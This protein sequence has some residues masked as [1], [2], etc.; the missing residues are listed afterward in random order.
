ML[1]VYSYSLQTLTTFQWDFLGEISHSNKIKLLYSCTFTLLILPP[2]KSANL[3][4]DMVRTL[5]ERCIV[6][7]LEAETMFS[8]LKNKH[9]Q[10][11]NSTF[12]PLPKL[13]QVFISRSALWTQTLH[14]TVVN[15]QKVIGCKRTA[16][17]KK[18]FRT[19]SF[20]SQPNIWASSLMTKRKDLPT[21][22]HENR[23]KHTLVSRERL[24]MLTTTVHMHWDPIPLCSTGNART[25]SKLMLPPTPDRCP[26]LHASAHRYLADIPFN[27]W[28]Y[29]YFS[30]QPHTCKG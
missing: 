18:G 9:R 13:K 26:E 8:H 21:I 16:L 20:D 23:A 10:T 28:P 3:F 2:V 4:R 15:R 27:F 22:Q 25:F 14:F 17:Q 19:L 5:E 6:Y 29:K 7:L 1:A 11:F 12:F 30:V 24:L